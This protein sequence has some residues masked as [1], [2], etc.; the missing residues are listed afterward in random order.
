MTTQKDITLHE[1]IPMTR[2]EIAE[3]TNQAASG[4]PIPPDKIVQLADMA[5]AFLL[6]ASNQVTEM[7][8]A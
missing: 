2:S 6:F 8:E 5:L 1:V 3:V 7:V 4:Q